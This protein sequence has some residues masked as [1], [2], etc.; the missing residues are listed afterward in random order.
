[1]R[2]CCSLVCLCLVALL[3]LGWATAPAHGSPSSLRPEMA[4]LLARN[5]VNFDAP[6]ERS[7]DGIPIGNGILGSMVWTP[8]D[9]GG[10][11]LQLN[12]TDAWALWRIAPDGGSIFAY[13]A[14]VKFE[15]DPRGTV[16]TQSFS[17]STH[18][19]QYAVAIGTPADQL[20]GCG[21]AW[22][23]YKRYDYTR[24]L[25]WLREQA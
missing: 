1:M 22:M 15:C 5:D 2:R 6:V 20:W 13:G 3:D 9:E 19:M 24:D 23:F 10:I 17:T 7:E 16:L 25:H 18:F 4:A 14:P 11:V 8:S 21:G 12:S